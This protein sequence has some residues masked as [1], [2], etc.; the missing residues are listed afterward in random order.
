MQLYNLD[1]DIGEQHNLY[2]D[3]PD[4]VAELENLFH[5]Y[6]KEGRSCFK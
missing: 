4:K 2:L 5:I 3:M 1:E 6:R